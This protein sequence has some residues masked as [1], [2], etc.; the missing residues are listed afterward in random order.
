MP[1]PSLLPERAKVAE[2]YS[3][4]SG[5]IPPLPWQTFP[6]PFSHE[7]IDEQGR[8]LASILN[9]HYAYFSVPTNL[10]AV[11]AVRHHVKVRWYLSL[12]RRSQKRKLTWRRMNVIVKKHL[13]LPTVRHPWP[14]QRFLVTHPR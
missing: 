4:G 9:G 6:P 12:L 11:R 7:P 5:T 14:E 13:P 8:R 1:P 10:C 2:F 3:A